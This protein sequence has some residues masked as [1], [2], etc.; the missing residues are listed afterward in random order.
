VINVPLPGFPLG[1]FV[2]QDGDNKPDEF[3]G[4]GEKRDNTN[5]KYLQWSDIA[6]S[7]GLVIDT[8]SYDPRTGFSARKT[9]AFA[10][11]LNKFVMDNKAP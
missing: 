5:F 9:P 2:V 1:L 4:L 11:R 10:I 7:S 6:A 8:D 3:D